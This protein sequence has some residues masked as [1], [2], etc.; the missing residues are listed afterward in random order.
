MK[1]NI[2]FLL[3]EGICVSGKKT[4]MVF[5]SAAG[6]YCS[7]QDNTSEIQ[8]DKVKVIKTWKLLALN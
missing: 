3:M 5:E 4:Y 1:K 2:F 6:K 8:I 7:N